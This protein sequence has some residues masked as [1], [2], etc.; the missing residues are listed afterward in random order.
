MT[1]V[2]HNA[3]SHYN[4]GLKL[5]DLRDAFWTLWTGIYFTMLNASVLLFGTILHSR[6]FDKPV[7]EKTF[8]LGIYFC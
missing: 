7:I 2:G 4:I 5:E 3:V 1:R 6:V 8:W